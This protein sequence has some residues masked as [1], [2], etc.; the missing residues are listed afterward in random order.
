MSASLDE[1]DRSDMLADGSA[2]F[3]DFNVFRVNGVSVE[4]GPVFE[5]GDQSGVV[6]ARQKKRVK[7]YR[8]ALNFRNDPSQIAQQVYMFFPSKLFDV[9]SILPDHNVCK[10]LC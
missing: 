2:E 8:K 10:H 1:V 6:G 5:D 7:A 4:C 9:V 3:R